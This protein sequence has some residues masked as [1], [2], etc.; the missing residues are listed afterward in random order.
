MK[1]RVVIIGSSF[2]GYSTALS[3]AKLFNNR[4]NITVIDQSPYFTFLPSLIWYPFGYRSSDD[5]SFDVRPIYQDHGI[6][7]IEANVY[8]MDLQ[9]QVIYTAEDDIP[10]DYLVIGTGS[11]PNYSGIK[12]FC[13]KNEI[14]SIVNLHDAEKT[15]LAWKRF[16]KNP[17]PIVIGASQWAGY[18]FA[19]YEFL[20]NVLYYLKKQH[21]LHEVPVHFITSEP[22]LTHF[23]I[24]GSPEDVTACEALFHR[25]GINYYTNA[26]IHELKKGKVVLEQGDVIESAFTMIIPE[27]IGVDAIRTTRGLTN[28]VGFLE[29]NNEFQHVQFPNI[30]GA[31]GA[32]YIEQENETPIPCGVPRTRYCTEIMAKTVAY[33]IASDIMGGSRVSVTNHR[34]YEYCKQDMGHLSDV[35]FKRAQDSSHDLDFIAKGS[36]DKWANMSIEQYIETSFDQDLLRI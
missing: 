23:G 28:A 31:G 13:E 9:E 25:Y 24:G 21:L 10:Y 22:Y 35:L 26:M 8:G 29:V 12:G 18:F 6:E 15:R 19:A 33:N 2:A 17:G 20:L 11:K 34:L 30:Y 32:V 3:L 36:Q 27:F 14:Y 7:F 1:K 5:I 4:H 16:L